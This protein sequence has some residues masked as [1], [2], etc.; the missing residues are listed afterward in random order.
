MTLAEAA[1]LGLATLLIVGVLSSRTVSSRTGTLM[2]T[3]GLLAIA[4]VVF[5]QWSR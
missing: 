1:V 4:L 2:I 5:R 3:V